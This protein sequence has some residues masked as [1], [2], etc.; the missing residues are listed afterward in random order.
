MKAVRSSNELS[1]IVE[2]YIFCTKCGMQFR[3]DFCPIC[4]QPAEIIPD[5]Y[6]TVDDWTK[7]TAAPITDTQA[8][9][10][11]VS[12]DGKKSKRKFPIVL[13]AVLLVLSI[14]FN[15]VQYTQ[16]LK[17]QETINTQ[18]QQV[19]DIKNQVASLNTSLAA[20]ERTIDS[21]KVKAG[22]YNDIC[23][24]LKYGNLGYASSNFKSSESII[25][26]G[27]NERD[28]K[29]TLTA[30]WSKGGNVSVSYSGK[31][32]TVSFDKNSWTTSTKMTVNPLKDGLTVVTFSNDVNSKTF[33]LLIIV[34]A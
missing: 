33:K 34:T 12:I 22:Y 18:K 17:A 27:K 4:G 10:K 31:S 28:R 7:Q 11:Q 32:A 9:I 3:G 21:L 14:G 26:V 6:N 24:E 30:N 25:V 16:N 13:L 20:K 15:T 5:G 8:E 23:K 19:E 29:F 2:N 1:P